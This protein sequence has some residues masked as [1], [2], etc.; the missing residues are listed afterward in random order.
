MALVASVAFAADEPKKMSAEE[1]AQMEAAMKAATPGDAHKKLDGMVGN[2]DA[3]VTSW[4]KPGDQPMKS[5]ATSEAHWV[6]GGR[7]V[8]EKVTGN[9]FGM[10]FNGIGYTGYDNLKKQYVGTWMDNFSTS[11]MTSTGKQDDAKTWTFTSSMD[12]PMTGKT[13]PVEEKFVIND[14]DHH[15]MEMWGPAPDGKM[16]KMMEITYTRKK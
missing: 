4:N 14:A 8:E 9:F 10:P 16:F 3:V 11:V 12:D 1:K 2:W 6:L 15:T 5:T 13:M 7:W